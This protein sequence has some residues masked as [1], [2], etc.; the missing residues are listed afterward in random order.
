MPLV[1][2]DR[3]RET[4][5]TT[6]TG[7]VTLAGAV[8]GFQSFISAMA[9]GDTTYYTIAGQG[10][11]E[12]EVGIG[13]LT[14]STTLA[15][16][17]IL[18][19][20]NNNTSPVNFSAGAKDVFI[21]YPAIEAVPKS[22]LDGAYETVSTNPSANVFSS[23]SW[24][25]SA[26]INS[27]ETV[28]V[29]VTFSPDGLNMYTSGDT[30]DAI[31]QYSLTRA[32]DVTSISYVRT[33]SVSAQTTEPRGITF[34][35]TGVFMY[36]G[37][38]LN[39]RVI[40]Y[41]L[42]TAWN[43]STAGTPTFF[44]VAG[45]ITSIGSGLQFRPDGLRMVVGSQSTTVVIYS[46]SVAWDIT[47]AALFRVNN[48]EANLR[49]VVFSNDGL[50]FFTLNNAGVI[51][52]RSPSLAWDTVGIGGTGSINQTV[53][54][55]AANF[56]I[57]TY[58]VPSFSLY[59]NEAVTGISAG[60]RMFSVLPGP[61]GSFEYI[62]QF[63][64]GSANSVALLANPLFDIT[65]TT[66]RQ[67]NLDPGPFSNY[68]GRFGVPGID[69]G[70]M[71]KQIRLLGSTTLISNGALIAPP[72]PAGSIISPSFTTLALTGGDIL[73]ATYAGSAWTVTDLDNNLKNS[74]YNL[75]N[76]SSGI[77][78]YNLI[79]NSLAP[80]T[81]STTYSQGPGI[82]GFV[83][84]S[85]PTGA[86]NNP[87][88][89][90]IIVNSGIVRANNRQRTQEFNTW[91]KPQY[92]N[93]YGEAYGYSPWTN[94]GTTNNGTLFNLQKGGGFNNTDT[95]DNYYWDRN[96]NTNVDANYIGFPIGFPRPANDRNSFLR[97]FYYIGD[98]ANSGRWYQ[99]EL[100]SMAETNWPS[101]ARSMRST[102]ELVL[103]LNYVDP[104]EDTFADGNSFNYA[105]AFAGDAN[106]APT[107]TRVTGQFLISGS[108]GT[109]TILSLTVVAT[110]EVYIRINGERFHFS[111]WTLDGAV[112][113]T[114]TG[115]GY[116]AQ[117]TTLTFGAGTTFYYN[118]WTEGDISTKTFVHVYNS[119]TATAYWTW[120][121]GEDR[122]GTVWRVYALSANRAAWAGGI[123]FIDTGNGGAVEFPSARLQRIWSLKSM[124]LPL[125]T[126]SKARGFTIQARFRVDDI[127]TLNQNVFWIA[128]GA[129]AANGIKVM[130]N[131]G[132]VDRRL[133]VTL[134]TTAPAAIITSLRVWQFND[135]GEWI[136]LTWTWNPLDTT[137]P[138]R[139]Y[140]NGVMCYK[141]ASNPFS[142]ATAWW[143][144]G[145][146]ANG[147]ANGFTGYFGY[148]T[149][150][151]EVWGAYIPQGTAL[152]DV[153]SG[154][155]AWVATGNNGGQVVT[156]SNRN[157]YGFRGYLRGSAWGIGANIRSDF[158]E[159]FDGPVV[160]SAAESF[161]LTG[162]TVLG[163][164]TITLSKTTSGFN[165]NPG[166]FLITGTGIP[167]TTGTNIYV[168]F[169]FFGQKSFDLF[170]RTGPINATSTANGTTFTFIRI[171]GTPSQSYLEM[172]GNAINV[173][174]TNAPASVI[175]T[176]ELA[177]INASTETTT[178]AFPTITFTAAADAG[179][180]DYY[181]T[182]AGNNTAVRNIQNALAIGK[183]YTASGTGLTATSA[184]VDNA[185]VISVAWDNFGTGLHYIQLSRN[186]DAAVSAGASITLRFV[187]NPS[188]T[189][190]DFELLGGDNA[191]TNDDSVEIYGYS[192]DP[193]WFSSSLGNNGGTGNAKAM[194]ARAGI[195]QWRFIRIAPPGCIY[196]SGVFRATA[197]TFV[198]RMY[199]GYGC[200]GYLITYGTTGDYNLSTVN[201]VVTTLTWAASGLNSDGINITVTAGTL[202]RVV[203][204]PF[205]P[206][207]VGDYYNGQ[208]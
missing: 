71:T 111:Y 170:D 139:L 3:V 78:A 64:L 127:T 68:I 124:A 63:Q 76:Q 133:S 20:S 123:P 184:T 122:G 102:S 14:N 173:A 120:L 70:G 162:D 79:T 117:S 176:N 203:I 100:L 163:S 98:Q 166:Y 125:T 194:M 178:C 150:V 179:I 136:I 199:L 116:A 17:T 145:S 21:T 59:L 35:P 142:A 130:I 105:V 104:T 54:F 154:D 32:F 172:P 75:Q 80:R 183:V 42:S 106:Q 165:R 10:N 15:R 91:Q 55:T 109:P 169:I 13:T 22:F 200:I 41:V 92:W 37:D 88:L 202:Y 107:G 24:A 6:G 46:L 84:W 103:G 43:I 101:T 143:N 112:S 129:A 108:I 12:W 53:T 181:T 36:V 16:T 73:Q 196:D 190:Q 49:G 62:G 141:T 25:V 180:N 18:D 9:V 11:N 29:G 50:Q 177:G 208:F 158:N 206:T 152:I 26:N 138:G 7:S 121:L 174:K 33:F 8:T 66:S 61:A 40:R 2:A 132:T 57:A 156:Y 185:R 81:L 204:L 83:G 155:P 126:D 167:T 93:I 159:Y 193:A 51:N 38:D 67:V 45:Q 95:P 77:V 113:G 192:P 115:G 94:A 160:G 28:N 151:P 188:C 201:P 134:A 96:N 161:T 207:L 74:F 144:V 191:K 118:Y 128:N 153:D 135:P 85:N 97:N 89:D 87:T 39:N 82:D 182:Q 147:T 4:T 164:P 19:T 72:P 198:R 23:G 47:T 195:G 119:N 186:R 69:F 5:T 31:D 149:F 60:I 1:L 34:D 56:P 131:E 52:R 99:R 27:N 168:G 197:S 146:T 30:S 58:G 110:S 187:P 140:C 137:F 44:S 48:F 171:S 114:I 157:N 90:V 148:L 189:F 65:T 205:N 175:F 86:T